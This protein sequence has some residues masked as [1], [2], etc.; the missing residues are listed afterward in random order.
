MRFFTDRIF[1]RGVYYSLRVYNFMVICIY[2]IAESL[3]CQELELPEN[4][5]SESNN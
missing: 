4:T 3:F 1:L 5:I 2:Q